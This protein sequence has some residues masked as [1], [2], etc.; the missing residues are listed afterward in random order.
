MIGVFG[1][2]KKQAAKEQEQMLS[3]IKEQEQE[4]EG[5]KEQVR[6]LTQS[7]GSVEGNNAKALELLEE[8]E[9]ER[10]SLDGALNRVVEYIKEVY[11]ADQ[12]QAEEEKRLLAEFHTL[13]EKNKDAG[14]QYEELLSEI[15][16]REKELVEL[17]DQNK[18]ITDPTHVLRQSVMEL[19]SEMHQMEEP[20]AQMEGLGHQMGVVSL[21]AAIEAG[22]M[23]ESGRQFV[24]AA[25]EVRSCAGKYQEESQGMAA[26]LTQMKDKLARTQ[27]QVEY[28]MDIL[29]AGSETLAKTVA[30]FQ[31]SENKLE[32]NR[33]AFQTDAWNSLL[34]EGQRVADISE[35]RKACFG[36]TMQSMEQAG[37]SFMKEQQVLEQMKVQM[38]QIKAE[39]DGQK[40]EE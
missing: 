35:T 25:E 2:A 9:T 27:E 13:N 34:E 32:E 7:F 12:E 23:G 38:K 17:V 14:K 10:T 8:V 16:G 30:S 36:H 37:V 5:L 20:L 15:K 24:V 31:S 39:I 11:G 22:R 4:L 3:K 29:T 1:N 19:E 40:R 26:Q 6:G 28:L 21:N 18:N 33:G